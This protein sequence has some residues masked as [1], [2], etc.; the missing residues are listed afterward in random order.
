[1]KIYAATA[2]S[3]EHYENEDRIVVGKTILNMGSFE[4]EIDSGLLAIA[5]GVGGQNAGA[6][7]SR[8]ESTV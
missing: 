2:K 1:M 3:L 5:D 7:A 6:V 4:A 8:V